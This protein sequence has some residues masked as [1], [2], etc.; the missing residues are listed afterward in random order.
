MQAVGLSHLS[1]DL[2][3]AV[4]KITVRIM[5]HDVCRCVEPEFKRKSRFI[6]G[7]IVDNFLNLAL[8]TS[9][10][11]SDSQECVYPLPSN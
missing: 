9:N 8:L 11:R 4:D 5:F 2:S 7:A 3:M 10:Q 1:T 6:T